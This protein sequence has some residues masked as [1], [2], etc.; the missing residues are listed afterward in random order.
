MREV[1]FGKPMLGD[2][3]KQAVAEVLEGDILVHGPKAKEFET[4][5]AEFTGSPNAVSTSNCTAA[6]HLSHFYFGTGPGDEVIVPAMTHNATAHAVEL[7]GATPVFVDAEIETGNIDISKIEE[8]ITDKTKGISIVHFLGMPV[9]MDKVMEIAEK[10]KLY[11]IEDCALSPGSTYKGKHTGLFGDAG[12]FSFY[13]VKHMT[14]GEG[15]ML[16]TKHEEMAKKIE[17]QRAFGVDRTVSERKVPGVYDVNMLG[18]NYR[19][20]EIHAA[21]GIGQ[22]KKLQG[23]IDKRKENY[24]ALTKGLQGIDGISLFKSTGGD[25]VS[26]Y[27]CH[28]VILDEALA[29]KRYEIVSELKANGV[30]TSV[31]Y[32]E[33]VTMFTYYREK[34]GYKAGDYPVAERISKSSISLP[35]GPHL[36]VEDMEYIAE[37]LQNA[38]RKVK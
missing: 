1:R 25:F 34:Y 18:F 31:Y 23:F 13:P 17:R 11:V 35:V 26:N 38:I 9:A 2:E 29:E 32:P 24:D 6:L 20:S 12:C 10:H 3:E 16:I 7:T 8:K 19:M 37:Q 4:S 22:V 27:Y 30:G 21:L 28:Q 5:F 14:T 15:G 36:E 33:A